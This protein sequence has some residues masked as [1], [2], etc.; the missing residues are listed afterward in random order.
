VSTTQIEDAYEPFAAAL[1]AGGFGDPD[2]GW[3]AG[4]IGAHIA[5]NNELLSEAAETL[6]ETGAASYDNHAAVD[7]DGLRAYG[8]QCGGLAGLADAVRASAARLARAYENLTEEERERPVPVLIVDGGR[9]VADEP[10]PLGHLIPGN[11][12]FHLARHLDQLQSLPR[13]S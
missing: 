5:M 4:Q 2:T 1:R 9:V 12:D 11:G 6:H 7:D 8:L 3:T 10:M 13:K